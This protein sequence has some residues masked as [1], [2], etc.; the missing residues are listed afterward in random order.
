MIKGDKYCHSQ[1]FVS[2]NLKFNTFCSSELVKM[3]PLSHSR[4]KSTRYSNKLHDFPRGYKDVCVNSFL[5]N[6]AELWDS[7]QNGFVWVK[8]ERSSIATIIH[9]LLLILI[10]VWNINETYVFIIK[11]KTECLL[12]PE[13]VLQLFALLYHFLT[14][15]KKLS[16]L[17]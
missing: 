6:T 13:S 14:S 9:F 3:A 17:S 12:L 7:E 1:R 2:E 11:S 16:W 5:L 4:E 8:S 10:W 15:H